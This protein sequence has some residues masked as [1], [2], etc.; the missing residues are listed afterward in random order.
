MAVA[1]R[2]MERALRG[3]YRTWLWHRG[4][5]APVTGPGGPVD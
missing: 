2:L 5:R 1:H 3:R 4:Y